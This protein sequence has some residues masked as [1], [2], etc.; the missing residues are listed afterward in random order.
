MKCSY[1]GSEDLKKN[2]FEVMNY[3]EPCWWGI[4]DLAWLGELVVKTIAEGKEPDWQQLR[5]ANE[6][7]KD[8]N[9]RWENSMF[10]IEKVKEGK[11]VFQARKL[12]AE[13]VKEGE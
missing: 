6:S 11:S 2:G 10:L 7:Q 13:K 9:R 8:F 3:C 5:E 4:Q 1:C 12:L